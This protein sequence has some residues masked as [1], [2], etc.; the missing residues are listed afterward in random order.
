[1]AKGLIADIRRAS[2]HDGAGIRTTVFFKGCPLRCAWCHNPECISPEPQELF[3]RERCIGCGYCAD[4]CFSGARV[5]C[6]KQM[7]PEEV[8]GEILL[9]LPYYDQNGGVTFTGGEPLMQADFLKECIALCKSEGI[10]CAVET[11]MHYFDEAL[12]RSLDFVMAD[13]KIWDDEIHRCYT[14]VGNAHI[15]E[16]FQRLNALG[17]PIIARTPV[18]PEIEQGIDQ[19]SAFLHSLE[20]VVRYELLPYHTLGSVKAEAMGLEQNIFSVPSGD[21]MKELEQYAYVRR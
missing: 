3:Y 16:H 8:L 19:I 12:F 4:G 18:I 9:D 5:I 10:G 14:G 11:S 21:L 2:F 13:L 17:V 15:K 6:G 20:N 1:M 7:T